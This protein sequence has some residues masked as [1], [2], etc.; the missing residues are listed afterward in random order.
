MRLVLL[1]FAFTP[2]SWCYITDIKTLKQVGRIDIEDMRLIQLM[3]PDYQI[4][5]KFGRK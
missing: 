4:S 2:P 5:N 1:E 3:H